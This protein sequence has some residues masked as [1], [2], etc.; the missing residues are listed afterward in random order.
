MAIN[1]CLLIPFSFA[2]VMR[3]SIQFGMLIYLGLNLIR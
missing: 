2:I 1:C 3:F